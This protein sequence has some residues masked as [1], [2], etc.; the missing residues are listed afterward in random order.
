MSNMKNRIE[1]W[2]SVGSKKEFEPNE[3]RGG[4]T[5]RTSHSGAEVGTEAPTA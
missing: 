3:T 2:P 1:I 4:I 5:S